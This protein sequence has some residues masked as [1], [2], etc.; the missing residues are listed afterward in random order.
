MALDHVSLTVGDR[1]R[2]AAFYSQHF[3]LSRPLHED[4]HLLVLASDEGSVLALAAGEVP[5][6]LPRTNHFGFRLPDGD[7]VRAARE[8]FRA[9]GVEEAEWQ[10]DGR[11]VRVQVFDPDGYRVEAYTF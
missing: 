3:G 7:A 9:A 4:E 5:V 2:S 10:D 8:R 1:E 11:F 6:D